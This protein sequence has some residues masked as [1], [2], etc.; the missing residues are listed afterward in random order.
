M[1]FTILGGIG[2]FLL[3]MILMTEGLKAAAGDALRRVLQRLTGGPVRAL[4]SGAAMTALV[5][6]SSATTLATIGF[7]SAGLLTFPQAIGVIFGANLGTTSTGWIVS[8]LGLKLN[9]GAMALPLIGI[10]ALAR[11]LMRGRPSTLGL[12]LAGFGL[13]FVGIDTLT[14]GMESLAERIDAAALPGGTWLGRLLLV[15]IGIVM[16]VVMQSSSAAVAATLT[17][18]H[19]GAIGLADG[20]A[21]VI[22]QN[23]GTTVTAA[24]A[25][26]GASVPAKRT[27]LAHILFNL[28]TAAV[29]FAILPLFLHGV[30]L[31]NTRLDISGDA[32]TL[33]AFHTAFNLLGVLLLLPFVTPFARMV[34]KWIP[35]RGPQ[36][37]RLLDP[38]VAAIA[39]V[40][41]DTARRTALDIAMV[42]LRNVQSLARGVRRPDTAE[43]LTA[44]E[45]AVEATRAFLEGVRTSADAGADHARHIAVLHALDHL[46]RL[47]VAAGE[48]R[49]VGAMTL[50]GM[51]PHAHRFAEG[52]AQ[53]LQWLEAPTDTTP[54]PALEILSLEL[55]DT[56]RLHRREL[57]DRTASGEVAPATADRELDALRW[58]DRLAY[59]VWRSMHHLQT[60][61]AAVD[62]HSDAPAEPEREPRS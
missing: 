31:V 3:G 57:L 32:A 15:G 49:H 5:Q 20:A 60:G 48:T 56:R 12:A 51:H 4:A 61:N 9:V 37:T 21:L 43:E 27:A 25:Q 39:P 45:H 19:A 62:T 46:D 8:L 13:I 50:S 55:A 58:I 17:A 59:H 40:A 7:V 52:L 34:I 16:S 30:H 41:L 23:V 1:I 2:L 6:S 28:L 47:I 53:P 38:S 35:D 10:G 26:I 11:L 29:A 42:V 36:L 44:A 14:A 33:A 22:G 24:I 18:L 54:V